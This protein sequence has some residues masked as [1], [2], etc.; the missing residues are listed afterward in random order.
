M[1]HPAFKEL[2]AT[3]TYEYFHSLSSIDNY[4]YTNNKIVGLVSWRWDASF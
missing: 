1:I 3:L 2:M 4:S